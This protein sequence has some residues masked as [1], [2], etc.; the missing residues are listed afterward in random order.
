MPDAPRPW[1]NRTRRENSQHPVLASP[2]RCPS[3]GHC[4][5]TRR[6][7]RSPPAA[8]ATMKSQRRNPRHGSAAELVPPCRILKQPGNRARIRSRLPRR[9]L[10]RR[11]TPCQATP[12]QA[13]PGHGCQL[14][15]GSMQADANRVSGPNQPVNSRRFRIRHRGITRWSSEF[16]SCAFLPRLVPHSDREP[17]GGDNLPNSA[18]P[19]LRRRLRSLAGFRLQSPSA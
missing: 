9:F 8:M 11:A 3:S 6:L 2:A 16:C 17:K 14:P 15:S 18:L 10:L 12:C 4:S 19:V 7:D 13:S 1:H 5:P